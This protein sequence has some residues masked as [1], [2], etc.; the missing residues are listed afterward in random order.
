ML[1]NLFY[2]NT[3]KKN[4]NQYITDNI[5]E[6]IFYNLKKNNVKMNQNQFW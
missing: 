3:W 1:K 4:K 6:K 5:I 2:R